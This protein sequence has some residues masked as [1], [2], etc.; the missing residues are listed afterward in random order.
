MRPNGA[1]VLGEM[2]KPTRDLDG[3]IKSGAESSFAASPIAVVFM[4]LLPMADAP[5]AG[6]AHT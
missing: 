4:S 5:E 2:V 1:L 6:G 3:E